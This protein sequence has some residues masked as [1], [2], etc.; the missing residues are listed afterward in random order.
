MVKPKH[1]ACGL[2]TMLLVTA[3]CAAQ[4][5]AGQTTVSIIG[6]VVTLDGYPV[7]N[8]QVDLQDMLTQTRVQSAYTNAAG[9]FEISYVAPG[10]YLVVATSGL[11]QASASIQVLQMVASPE[12]ILRLPRSFANTSTGRC[13]QCVHAVDE[14]SEQGAWRPARTT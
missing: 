8:A 6:R 4:A 13:E 12:L 10:M 9:R 2:I 1:A 14:S 3:T 11:D 5:P 7:E